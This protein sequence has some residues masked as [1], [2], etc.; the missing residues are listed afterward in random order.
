MSGLSDFW[1]SASIVEKWLL[2][3]LLLSVVLLFCGALY[4]FAYKWRLERAAV[5]HLEK[6]DRYGRTSHGYRYLKTLVRELGR[7][8]AEDGRAFFFLR[9]SFW[10]LL[11]FV[12]MAIAFFVIAELGG[13][14]EEVEETSFVFRNNEGFTA[15]L[16]LVIALASAAMAPI[17]VELLNRRRSRESNIR[18]SEELLQQHLRQVSQRM[19]AVWGHF[20]E[21]LFP[22]VI[23]WI[24][25]LSQDPKMS[26]ENQTPDSVNELPVLTKNEIESIA[27]WF[28]EQLHGEQLFQSYRQTNKITS[29]DRSGFMSLLR[30]WR[31]EGR[32]VPWADEVPVSDKHPTGKPSSFYEKDTVF[33]KN[34]QQMAESLFLSP[35]DLQSPLTQV[36]RWG[37]TGEPDFSQSEKGTTYARLRSLRENWV[38]A[39]AFEALPKRDI[40]G[41]N[42]AD[43]VVSGQETIKPGEWYV[44][45]ANGHS[46]CEPA[47]GDCQYRRK[48][49]TEFYPKYTA[50]ISEFFPSSELTLLPLIAASDDALARA[51]IA[52]GPNHVEASD[53]ND[54]SRSSESTW[55]MRGLGELQRDIVARTE[56][57]LEALKRNVE[58]SRLAARSLGMSIESLLEDVELFQYLCEP[59]DIEKFGHPTEE[60]DQT[61]HTRPALSVRAPLAR[62]LYYG[63]VLLRLKQTQEGK[64][65]VLRSTWQLIHKAFDETLSYAM[66]PTTWH[67]NSHPRVVESKEWPRL[68]LLLETARARSAVHN[69]TRAALSAS[70][71]SKVV[72]AM[73]SALGVKMVNRGLGAIDSRL[74]DE[75]RV[76]SFKCRVDMPL[77]ATTR[78]RLTPLAEIGAGPPPD[79]IERRLNE[80]VRTVT[81]STGGRA[82]RDSGGSGQ[83]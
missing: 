75:V 39:H 32:R 43:I 48:E 79:Y 53:G 77:K 71:R 22:F 42:A 10:V 81:N 7:E 25:F 65:D 29:E 34:G 67:T 40:L 36:Q 9:I 23:N 82:V 63:I 13:T 44:W 6:F 52:D 1:A 64:S 41:P 45:M 68:R 66:A 50:A 11:W 12:F 24:A 17:Y 54:G 55:S 49:I 74:C 18:A 26:L 69:L 30:R 76:A 14:K 3:G 15:A 72:E 70:R 5:A 2:V 57:H 21:V 28:S 38:V 78:L 73:P 47:P 59:L 8:R 20:E 31:S 61:S 4:E 80:V 56:K 51:S 58:D 27:T 62:L 83:S 37:E 19:E 35:S 46:L 60:A 16:A 33:K